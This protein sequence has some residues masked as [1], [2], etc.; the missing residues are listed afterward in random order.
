MPD[1]KLGKI[2][3]IHVQNADETDKIYVG[4]TCEKY[5]SKRYSSHINS[6]NTWLEKK[7][8]YVSVFEIFLEEAPEYCQIT[9]LESYPCDNKDQ[10]RARER[11]YIEQIQ[12]VNKVMPISTRKDTEKRYRQKHHTTVRVKEKRYYVKNRGKILEKQKVIMTCIC[13]LEVNKHH[14]SRH[15]KSITH[16]YLINNS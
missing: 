1:Y 7:K 2:Y 13:G 11:Y 5:L 12:C 15:K 8:S 14:I 6:F 3:K 10:L 16:K 4:S 9:L